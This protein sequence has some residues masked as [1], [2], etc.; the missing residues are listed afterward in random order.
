MGGRV[1]FNKFVFVANVLADAQGAQ[2]AGVE[3]SFL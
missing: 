2:G 3:P 1:S